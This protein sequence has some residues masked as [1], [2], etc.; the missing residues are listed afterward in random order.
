VDNTLFSFEPLYDD[1]SSD[2]CSDSEDEKNKESDDYTNGNKKC[3]KNS[4][5]TMIDV[6]CKLIEPSDQPS[7]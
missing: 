1:V 6:V 5:N 2:S 7:D 4:D 3:Y